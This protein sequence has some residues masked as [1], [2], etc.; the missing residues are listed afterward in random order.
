MKQH[1]KG[2]KPKVAQRHSEGSEDA[3]WGM[4]KEEGGNGVEEVKRK[5]ATGVE[6]EGNKSWAVKPKVGNKYLMEALAGTLTSNKIP[7]KSDN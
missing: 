2:K 3:Q 6:I 7:P 4:R 5:G 1:K